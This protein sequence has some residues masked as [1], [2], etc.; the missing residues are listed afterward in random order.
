MQ[1]FAHR[2]A[3]AYFPENTLVAFEKAKEMGATGIETDVQVTKDGVLVL[4]HDEKVDRTTDGVGYVKDLT[5]AEIQKFNA[6]YY[7]KYSSC[8]IP[9]VE[10]ALELAKNQNLVINF[11]LKESCLAFLNTEEK[12]INTIH[13]YDMKENVIISSFHLSSLIR[14]RSIDPQIKLAYLTTKVLKLGSLKSLGIEIV[15]PNYFITTRKF[16]SHL[17]QQNFRINVFTVN[18]K[19]YV[20]RLLKLGVDGLITDVPDIVI[21]TIKNFKG[22]T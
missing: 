14:C 8:K 9:T 3:S 20:E 17:K 16:V 22:Y 19:K 6:G 13:K 18:K 7:M 11:E 12:L 10:E 1:I 4:I 15:H 21:E 2:G 5:F